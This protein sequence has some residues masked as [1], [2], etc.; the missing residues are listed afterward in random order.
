MKTSLP[1]ETT[2][3]LLDRLAEANR[4][5]ARAYP[6]DRGERQPVHTVYGG[7]HLFRADSAPRMGELARGILREFAP[8]APALSRALGFSQGVPAEALYARIVEKLEREPVEDFR[9]D[10]EDGFGNRPDPEEDGEAARTALEVARGMEAG[11]LPPFVG[12]RVKAFTEALAPRAAR[13]LD[14]FLTALVGATGGRLPPGFVVTLP[15]VTIPEQAGALADLLDVLE[16]RLGLPAGSIPVELMVETPQAIVGPDG[17]SPLGRLLEAARGRCRG[18]HF[19]VYDYTAASGMTAAHQGM[20][21]PVCDFARHGMLAA[22]AGR[23]VFLSDGATNVIPVG[24]HP[25]GGRGLTEAQRRENR[26]AVLSAW[27][28]SYGHIRHSLRQGF[29]QGWDLHTAQLPVRYAAVFA[30]FLEG[31]ETAAARLKAFVE[32]A[33]QA[34]L[35]EDM[36]DDAATGQ[37]LLNFF[38]RATGC[39]AL[40]QEEATAKSGLRIEEMRT[41]SFLRI[42]EGRRRAAG[43]GA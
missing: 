32:R 3:P 12:I 40:S 27:R 38:L 33:A 42:L 26:E 5:F 30:F 37:A 43:G 10:F 28:L 19:G 20:D 22:L 36:F 15:K 18:A 24:P 35:V 14:P 23:G 13:T 17:R 6:G 7:A 11:S 41:R 2:K 25:A 9:I 39:G 34:T 1:P 29:Y 4:D 8:D 16:S 31:L 21:H